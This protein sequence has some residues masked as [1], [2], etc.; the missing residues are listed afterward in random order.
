[1]NYMPI[2]TL[3]QWIGASEARRRTYHNGYGNNGYNNNGY[4][5]N[6]GYSSNRY[7]N[8]GYQNNGYRNRHNYY[9][10]EDP[11]VMAP[12]AAFSSGGGGLLHNLLGA[13]NIKLGDLLKVRLN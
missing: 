7:G 5:N 12:Q 10:N 6:N 3:V 11:A 9:P 13:L 8:N 1:M 2:F 4:G